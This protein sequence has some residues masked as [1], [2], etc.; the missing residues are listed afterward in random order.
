LR[1]HRFDVIALAFSHDSRWL[2]TGSGDLTARVW[3]LQAPN[4]SKAFHVLRGHNDKVRGV[5]FSS[6]GR[7]LVT[8]SDDRSARIWDMKEE[9]PSRTSVVLQHHERIYKIAISED[10]HWVAVAGEEGTVRLWTLQRDDLLPA[11]KRAAGRNLRIDEWEDYFPGEP[12]RKLYDDMEIPKH[13]W[14]DDK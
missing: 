5:V 10:Q 9:D 3:D 4:P 13:L 1:G 2:A 12:Y 11:A 8:A 6:D 14:V 7:W